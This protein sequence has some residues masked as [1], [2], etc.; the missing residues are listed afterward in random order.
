[1]DTY[2]SSKKFVDV[3]EVVANTPDVADTS[4][5]MAD[6][7]IGS[8]VLMGFTCSLHAYD[9]LS[10]HLVKDQGFSRPRNLRIRKGDVETG[11]GWEYGTNI[12]FPKLLRAVGVKKLTVVSG[13]IGELLDRDRQEM[14]HTNQCKDQ[15]GQ[16][17]HCCIHPDSL[18]KLGFRLNSRR[19]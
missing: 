8:R 14:C 9:N 3:I 13:E 15:L 7:K 12:H 19:R 5:E 4:Q 1:M 11:L 17:S 2:Y 18:G 10:A 16:S 6:F